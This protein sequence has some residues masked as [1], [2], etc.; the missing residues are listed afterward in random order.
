VEEEQVLL[1]TNIA[2]VTLLSLLNACNE[3]KTGVT[4]DHIRRQYT[5]TAA[6]SPPQNP[7]HARCNHCSN[8]Y[9]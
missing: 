2:V 7:R 5:V 9:S 4:T 3:S 8:P 1:H 6:V